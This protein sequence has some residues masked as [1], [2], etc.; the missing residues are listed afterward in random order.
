M[1]GD[2]SDRLRGVL[3]EPLDLVILASPSAVDGLTGILGERARGLAVAVI[4]PVTEQAARD[5]GLDVRIVASPATA[6][7]LTTAA[8]RFFGERPVRPA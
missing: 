8:Q 6:Q 7:G 1:P 3:A 4:G 2:A 5:A